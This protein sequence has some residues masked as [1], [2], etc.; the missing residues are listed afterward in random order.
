MSVGETRVPARIVLPGIIIKRELDARGWTQKNLAAIVGRPAQAISEII[1]GRKRITAETALQ[2]AEAF[3]TSAAFWLNLESQHQLHLAQREY[4]ETQIAR[5]SRLYSLTPVS[6]LIKR[7]W[8][9]DTDS[10]DEL[11][12][13]VCTFLEIGSP[14]QQPRLAASLRQTQS[15]TPETAAQITWVKRVKHLARAQKVG[16]YNRSQV[17]AALPDLLAQ[18]RVVEG[19]SQVPALL[20][21]L[22]VH[23]VIVPHLPHT[24]LDG[25]AFE[26]EGHPVVALTLRYNRIDNFWFTLLHEL[27]HSLAGHQGL[28]LD[29]LDI[30][31]D[32][33]EEVEANRLAQDWLIDPDALTRFVNATKPYFSRK[34]IVAFAH[35]QG[36]HPGIIVGRLHHE[37]EMPHR[38]LRTWLAKVKP[39]LEDWIDS[40]GSN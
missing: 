27:A 15:R 39:Y 26:I 19:V 8:I 12:R 28:F 31:G 11:E 34:T 40:P 33:K 30:L 6:E 13:Y 25:A 7:G 2:L 38:N 36:R 35:Q 1:G 23:F 17:L 29:N 21:G 5:R 14:D 22:G 9:D 4:E 24:Y 16:E 32:S 10:I 37:D 20:H 3:G 18:A